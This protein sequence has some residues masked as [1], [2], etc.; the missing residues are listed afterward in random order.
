MK[1]IFYNK[2]IKK[3]RIKMVA[4]IA[5]TFVHPTLTALHRNLLFLII[6]IESHSIIINKIYSSFFLKY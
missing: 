2:N 4:A 5:Y 3:K 1:T 6:K